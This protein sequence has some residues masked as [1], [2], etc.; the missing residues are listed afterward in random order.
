M[1]PGLFTVLISM[2]SARRAAAASENRKTR[3]ARRMVLLDRGLGNCGAG[4]SCSFR[5]RGREK[6]ARD[7]TP[8]VDNFAGSGQDLVGGDLFH[9]G[10]IAPHLFDR[11]ADHERRAEYAGEPRLAISGKYG[12][13]D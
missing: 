9:F 3:K 12:F 6:D 4:H 11:G 13:R 1:P 10:R 5:P 2:A 8:E 7:R